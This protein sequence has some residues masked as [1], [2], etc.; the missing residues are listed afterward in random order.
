M[1]AQERFGYKKK[2]EDEV[3]KMPKMQRTVTEHMNYT[4]SVS[5]HVSTVTQVDMSLVA[6][7]RKELMQQFDGKLTFN[8]LIAHTLVSCLHTNRSFN[9]SVTAEGE[10]VHHKDVNLS[11]AVAS[12]DG[13]LLVPVIRGAHELTLAEL[14]TEMNCIA[15]LA[16]TRKLSVDNLRGGTFTLTNVGV[17]GNLISTPLINQPQ[18]AIMAVGAI[19]KQAVVIEDNDAEEIAIRPMM[20][21]TLTYDHRV[22]DGSRS[23]RFFKQFREEL[24]SSKKGLHE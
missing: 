14:A 20:Y 13:G 22:N 2:I 23:G 17:F 18:V 19:K 21:A 3:T 11:F 24:E 4:W 16:R 15:E 8:H 12:A 1:A 7:R 6:Q 5:P 9:V 10:I